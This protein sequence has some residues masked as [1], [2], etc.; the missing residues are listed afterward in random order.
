ML[1]PWKKNKNGDNVYI[2]SI[3]TKEE[4]PTWAEVYEDFYMN[5]FFV[6]DPNDPSHQRLDLYW[7]IPRRKYLL[8]VICNQFNKMLFEDGMLKDLVE[9]L[10]KDAW[11]CTDVRFSCEPIED[12]NP[13][14]AKGNVEEDYKKFVIQWKKMIDKTLLGST[15]APPIYTIPL[16][17]GEI[18]P[19][20]TSR[21]PRIDIN[22]ID[23]K[24]CL[25]PI[26]K[27]HDIGNEY[28]IA[29]PLPYE[30]WNKDKYYSIIE[31]MMKP[32]KDYFEG[33]SVGWKDE[34]GN[35]ILSEPTKHS[36]NGVGYDPAL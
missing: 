26:I 6:Y 33:D 4:L 32:F 23:R 18:N 10:N 7:K 17:S 21:H 14:N 22:A 9:I 31:F 12:Y 16:P 11:G 28:S 8:S 2:P 15:L 29:A 36:C 5:K 24:M 19:F 35:I 1:M 30:E 27:L 3:Y 34:N 13:A 25:I 20:I